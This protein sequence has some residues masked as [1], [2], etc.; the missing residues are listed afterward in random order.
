M[1]SRVE[2]R[3]YVRYPAPAVHCHRALRVLPPLERAGQRVTHLAWESDPPPDEQRETRDALGNRVLEL[4]HR[5]IARAWQFR[6]ELEVAFDPQPVPRATN[7][8]PEGLGAL[9]LPSAL[10]D[11]GSPVTEAWHTTGV[12]RLSGRDIPAH[13]S[14]AVAAQLC[15]WTHAHLRYQPAQGV[16]QGASP[17]LLAGRGMCAEFAHVMIALCRLSGVTARY[18]SGFNPTEGLMHAW[19]EALCGEVWLPFDPTHGRA[20]SAGSVIVACGRDARDTQ[21]HEGSYLG[22]P[23]AQLESHCRTVVLP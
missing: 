9:R 6:L 20:P 15:A 13:D 19:V 4:S 7:L 17:T 5:R 18:I 22:A 10:C 16:A 1:L 11:A 2:K 8:P 3:V 12:T 23:G 14:E 21:P